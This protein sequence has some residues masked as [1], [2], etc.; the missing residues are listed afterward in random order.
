MAMG[1]L[2]G[3][4]RPDGPVV[5]RADGGTSLHEGLS[6]DGPGQW[7]PQVTNG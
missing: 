2:G 6:A 5:R 4:G 7:Y 1:D 3:S